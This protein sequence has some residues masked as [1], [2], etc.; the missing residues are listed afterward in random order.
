MSKV[1]QDLEG[2][3]GNITNKLWEEMSRLRSELLEAA[4]KANNTKR[5]SSMAAAMGVESDTY[6]LQ[7]RPTV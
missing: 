2:R 4:E 6:S 3:L 7:L 5:R 1:G